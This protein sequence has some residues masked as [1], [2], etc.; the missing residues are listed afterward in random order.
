MG[1]RHAG[2]RA[3]DGGGSAMLVRSGGGAA[4][5]ARRRREDWMEDLQSS[6]KTESI[7]LSLLLSLI[8]CARRALHA[9]LG[10]A[11]VKEGAPLNQGV[12]VKRS[13]KFI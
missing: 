4:R 5:G 10:R 9:R 6:H 7:A 1:R 8:D 3:D 11:K 2:R 13:S 12:G